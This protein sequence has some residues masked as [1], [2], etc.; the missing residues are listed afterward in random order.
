MRPLFRGPWAAFAMCSVVLGGC[1]QNPTMGD[2]VASCLTPAST[3]ARTG[4]ALVGQTYGMAMSPLPL[5]SVQFGSIAVAQTAAVQSLFA[6]RT[7]MNTVEVSVRFLSCMDAPTT[8][9]VRTSFL[10]RNTSPAETASA[11]KSVYL[12][13]RTTAVY[14]EL[15]TSTDVGSYLIEVTR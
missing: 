4:P 9:L 8:I 13:P 15:S 7:A 3:G 2:V 12:E 14:T 1:A 10:R 6:A 11:W 5:N